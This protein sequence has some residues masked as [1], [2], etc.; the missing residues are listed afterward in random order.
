LNFAFR[1]LADFANE[2]INDP[3]RNFS[4]FIKYSF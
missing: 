4:A 3:G 1:N 2:P